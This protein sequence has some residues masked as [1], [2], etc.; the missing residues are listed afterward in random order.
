MG[1]GISGGF[2]E[3][4]GG[5]GD[6]CLEKNQNAPIPSEH[7]PARGAK[8]VKTF[9]WDQRLQVLLPLLYTYLEHSAL[10]VFSFLCIRF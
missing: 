10:L 5:G 4:Q 8:N 3:S 7:H 2:R 6:T 9:R 1:R